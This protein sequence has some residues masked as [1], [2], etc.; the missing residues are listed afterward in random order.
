M[1]IIITGAFGFVGSNISKNLFQNID[2]NLIAI[3]IY[4]KR[5]HLYKYFYNWDQLEKIEWNKIDVIIHLA[6]KAHDTRNNTDNATYFKI[7]TDL[8]KIIFEYFKKSSAYKFIFFSSVKAAAD[9]V[10]ESELTENIT[11][12]P[13]GPYGESKLKAEE[14]IIK[15]FDTNIRDKFYYILRP[16]M[17]H[18][19]GNKGNLNLLYK[20]ASKG[21]PWPLGAFENKR[22][23]TSIE[24]LNFIISQIIEKDIDPGIY[25]I[26]D[27]DPISTNMIIKLIS[28]QKSRK[29]CILKI[30]P[31]V[32]NFIAIIGE[33]FHLPLNKERLKKLTENYIVSN[34]KIKKALNIDKLPITVE[35]G[36]RSTLQSF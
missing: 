30:N 21:I 33:I 31:N 2:C 26:A 32:I 36:M 5:D 14:Y 15:N 24:N 16:S 9:S 27:D 10:I 12:C 29:A 3:D 11:P 19:P 1:N 22:S 23:F 6:G 28:E 7:N 34:E 4:E 8:T 20:I 13:K 25:Q 35:D 17:I 18:G